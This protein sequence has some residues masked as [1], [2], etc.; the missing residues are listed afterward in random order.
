MADASTQPKF[1]CRACGR[2]FAWRAELAGKSAKCACG[3]MVKVPA[4]P[5]RAAGAEDG[6][7]SYDL[8]AAPASPANKCRACGQALEAGA[9][10]C[11]HCGFN[12]KTGRKMSTTVGGDDEDAKPAKKRAPIKAV[13]PPPVEPSLDNRFGGIPTGLRTPVIQEEVA[14]YRT[15][16]KPAILM[17]ALL[18][19]V[20]A[21]IFFYKTLAGGSRDANLHPI[22]RDV[23]EMTAENGATELKAWISDK[24]LQQ[25]MVLGM[26]ENQANG[27]A[28][29]LYK[30]GA[31]K[32]LAFGHLLTMS[33]GVE[34]PQDAA[35]RAELFKFQT[36][37]HNSMAIAP[38]KDEGQKYILLKMKLVK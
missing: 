7:I 8:D 9:V 10:L 5:P 24:D 29:K 34:L 1:D 3:A 11:V 6:G 14:G 33:I 28:D 4:K 32:V 31:V 12:Q 16:I 25:R 20:A 2:Q 17:L 27:F 22:D 35:Q 15:L 18:L 19:V 36:E 26:N 23:K 21:A 30:M 13:P 37:W 38:Q